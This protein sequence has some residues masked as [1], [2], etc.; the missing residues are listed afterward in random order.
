MNTV[1]SNDFK[2]FSSSLS[3]AKVVIVP[4]DDD[5]EFIIVIRT[6]FAMNLIEENI[7]SINHSGYLNAVHVLHHE[8][9]HVHDYNKCLEVFH[10]DFFGT[11]KRG[12]DMVLFPLSQVCWSEYIANYMSRSSA[13]KSTLPKSLFE[14]FALQISDSQINIQKK[15]DNFRVDK[16][17]KSLL[18]YVNSSIESL[19]KSASYVLGYMHG[20]NKQIGDL[21]PQLEEVISNSY[22]YYTWNYLDDVLSNM[23]KSYPSNWNEELIFENLT[24]GFDKL[25]VRFGIK[26]IENENNELFFEIS[27]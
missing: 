4:K 7:D 21:H 26:L 1:K 5:F 6:D 2:D 18:L 23:R 20:M 9:C 3:Y 25:Y 15:I 17:V 24:Y 14:S 16:D 22:F 8:L 13:K 19:V 10:E 27:R 12:K 11:N